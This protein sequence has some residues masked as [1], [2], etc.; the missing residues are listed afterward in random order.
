MMGG[1]GFGGMQQQQSGMFGRD[2]LEAREPQFGMQQG[3]QMGGAGFGGMQQQ[4]SSM[5]GRELVGLVTR[6]I[7]SR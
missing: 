3:Q 6:A 1:G 2:E 4:Q 5:F 7:A